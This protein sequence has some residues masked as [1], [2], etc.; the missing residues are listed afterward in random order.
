M[1]LNPHSLRLRLWLWNA[2]MLGL[3]LAA[4][5]VAVY[6]LL[7]RSLSAE[8]DRSLADR[9]QQVN[10]SLQRGGRPG[11][12]GRVV[13][14]PPDTFA[15]A[16]TFV[17]VADLAGTVLG[18][19]ENLGSTNLPLST[20]D[21]NRLHNGQATYRSVRVHGEQLRLFT[22]P[23]VLSGEPVGVI[24]VARS[25][26][27]RDQALARLRRFA[28]YGVAAA[29][30]LSAVGT[31]LVVGRALSPLQNLIDTA[32]AV[33]FSG[34]LKRRVAPPAS[35]D[36]VGRLAVTFN[37]M[38]DRLEAS[39]TEIRRAY[40]RLEGALEAQRRFV[41]DAS[42]ELRTPL[43]TIRGNAGLLQQYSDITPQ[44]RAEALS[45][46]GQEAERMSRLVQDLLTLARADAGQHL[47][48]RPVEL[49]LLTE[50]VV[51]QAR[52]LGHAHTVEMQVEPVEVLGDQDALHQLVLI[53][54]EN[55]VKYT[56]PGGTVSVRLHRDGADAVLAVSD[57]GVGIAEADLPH[58]FERFYRADQA[59]QAGGTGLG[60]SIA[61]WIASEHSGSITARSRAGH[62]SVFEVRL[63]A[64]SEAAPDAPPTATLTAR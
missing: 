8:I 5:T 56:P 16:D 43:T 41:A 47:S 30:L 61:Q 4:F 9:A 57:T 29:L 64:L 59:R 21:L 19:S 49:D 14:P 20:T 63:P 10:N 26:Q 53:L 24:Q 13:V 37:R 22:A 7:A 15:T 48:R 23:L 18:A 58:I 45:Q 25:F 17:Q 39:D 28:G 12:S 11:L 42:H 46:I 50:Q 60:L 51:S 38:L 36:E 6:G 62:G 44:D 32:Q 1:R 35:E 40:D 27:V 3:L 34:D 54:L 52:R 2:L 31:L 33:A 55:A